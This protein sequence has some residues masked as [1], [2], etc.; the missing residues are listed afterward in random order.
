M[1]MQRISPPTFATAVIDTDPVIE[2]A[3]SARRPPRRRGRPLGSRSRA[4]HDR[5]AADEFAVLRAVAQGVDIGVA[6]RQ[7]LFWPGRVPERAH[8][9]EQYQELLQRIASAAPALPDAATAEHMVRDLLQL[10]GAEV[11][12][13][14]V[15]PEN[16]PADVAPIESGESADALPP[17]PAAA[18][19]PTLEEFAERFVGGDWSENELLEFYQEEFAEQ[20]AAQNAKT[21]APPSPAPPAMVQ[22]APVAS[23]PEVLSASERIDRLLAAID[24]LGEHLAQVP[25]REHPCEQWLRLNAKQAQ[26]LR[27]AGVITLGNLVDWMAL[28]GQHWYA[29]IPGFGATRATALWAWLSRSGIKAGVGLHPAPSPQRLPV[30]AQGMAALMQA[31]WSQELDGSRGVFRIEGENSLAAS[32]DRE[33]VQAWFTL[34]RDKSPATQTA[35]R[36]A[37]ERLTLWAI[38]EK[39]VALSSLT[40]MDVLEF[41]AFLM[42][43]PASWV[44]VPQADR[45]KGSPQWRPLRAPLT[46]A[47]L[48]LTFA[49]IGSMYEH[50]KESHYVRVNPARHVQP[51]RRD[52]ATMDVTRS[53]TEHDLQVMAQVLRAQPDDAATRRLRALLMLLEMAGLRREEVVGSTWG[54]IERPVVDGV[55]SQAHVL[56][57]LGKGSRERMVPLNVQIIEA[58]SA[59]LSDRKAL[60]AQ[61]KLQH[62]AAL[63]DA[64]QPLIGVLDERTLQALHHGEA[65]ANGALSAQGIYGELKAFWAKCSVAA[66]EDPQ[67]ARTTFKR[68][69]PH[70]LRHTFAHKLLRATHK[71]LP[72]VQAVL[73]HKSI[74]TT[75][76][77]VKA[78]LAARIEATDAMRSGL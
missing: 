15:L 43:P 33:A 68:A 21:S 56:R 16:A 19:L 31:P 42:D 14:G 48:K 72:L 39:G 47:S 62:C 2:S 69:S 29:S 46:G 54:K 28:R 73:G 67:E 25:A 6:A 52:E 30:T 1:N 74:S 76:I 4:T 11:A 78:D 53:F 32:N 40:Q 35:Y 58:L 75:A 27:N 51:A 34:M 64:E 12:S 41:R 10:Q 70:W 77:Y 37:I 24:W 26:A 13:V 5:I 23:D 20:I 66:G 71:D 50:W 17:S 44:Q 61:G 18:K 36:R 65:D 38:H 55:V 9:I 57:V 45:L 49:A 60:M 59:H 22:A 3:G 8:L 7:Y 63:A